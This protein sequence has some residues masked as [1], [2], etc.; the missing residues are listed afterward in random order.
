MASKHR[1]ALPLG[2]EM[3]GYRLED[4]LGAGGFGITYRAVELSL[5]RE[6]AIKEY[7]PSGIARRE[8]GTMTVTAVSDVAE[9]DY[10]WGLDR[11][12]QEAKV[13]VTFRHPNIVPVLRFFE[14]NNTAY[15]V[16]EYQHGES[17][18]QILQRD[19]RL[20]EADILELVHPVLE[21]LSAVHRAGFLHRDI[22]PDNIFIRQDGTPLLIDFGSARQALGQHSKSLTAIISEG[23]A[24]YEQYQTG[25]DQ[26]PAS[27]IY[28]LGAVMYRCVTGYKPPDAPSRVT[29]LMQ[30]KDDPMEAASKTGRKGYSHELLH[31]I[32]TALAVFERERP[33]S[34][35]EFRDLLPQGNTTI[36]AR[37]AQ[38]PSA[39]PARQAAAA[40]ART[41][42]AGTPKWVPIAAAAGL[43]IAIAGG[44]AAMLMGGDG[45]PAGNDGQELVENDTGNQ[46]TDQD[47]QDETD[48]RTENNQDTERQQND[49]QQNDQQQNADA[50]AERRR[51]EQEAEQR[52]QAE[53]EAERRR[54]EQ[55]AEQRQQAEAEAERRRQE[56]LERQR[57]EAEAQ[58][59][60]EREQEQ[61]QGLRSRFSGR[62]GY[63]NK[64]T[65]ISNGSASLQFAFRA[66]GS[67]TLSWHW[68]NGGASQAGRA[69]GSWSVEGEQLCIQIDVLNSGRNTCYAITF[70][71]DGSR[72]QL[73]GSGELRGQMRVTN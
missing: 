45:D 25:G 57:A 50:E 56:Q 46:T 8:G 55:E 70:N 9:E 3:E 73:S 39:K 33:Q 20:T 64:E 12:R 32:D 47:Q 69:T 28:A 36:V 2:T 19:T 41:K 24:P 22:K 42:Q 4:I 13:L 48:T 34:V 40:P 51:Q 18:G 16:M 54:Q 44:G 7:L 29:S 17:L 35:D 21:G 65:S 10:Q 15:L 30:E 43:L 63:M 37:R 11:F 61:A 23:Y 71:A 68:I 14:A 5:D 58:Q 67:L 27:D 26:G 53:A 49:Q 66:N 6:V 62:T 59:Q 72:A 38:A 52:R 1:D 31:A 60:L